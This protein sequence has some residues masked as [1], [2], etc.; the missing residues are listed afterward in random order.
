MDEQWERIARST[1]LVGRECEDAV[2]GTT[3]CL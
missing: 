2:A 3:G 1:F